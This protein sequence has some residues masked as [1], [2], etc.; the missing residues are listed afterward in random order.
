[1]VESFRTAGRTGL[2]PY[3]G[4]TCPSV[5][6]VVC[7]CCPSVSVLLRNPYKHWLSDNAGR[8]SVLSALVRLSAF[9][10]IDGQAV[11]SVLNPKLR[12]LFEVFEF[13]PTDLAQ[14]APDRRYRMAHG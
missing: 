11:L 12:A 3:R 7:P 2:F 14:T 4:G 10:F 5:A 13:S 9:G 8:L 1:M 6:E